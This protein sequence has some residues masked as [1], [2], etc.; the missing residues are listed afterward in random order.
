MEKIVINPSPEISISIVSHGQANLVKDLLQ[1]IERYCQN[2]FIEVL[3]TLN[4]EESLPFTPDSFSFP[5]KF[6]NNNYPLGFGANHNQAFSHASG[7][8]FCVLNPD[9]R[10]DINPFTI[11]IN[12]LKNDA[13]GIVAPI[14][15]S[16]NNTIEDSARQFP[17][18]F[19][20]ICKA[21]GRRKGSDYIIQELPI[22]PDWVGGMFMLFPRK[23][24]EQLNG[25]DEGYFLYYEDVDLCARLRL[26]NYQI[27]LCPEV[28]VYHCAQRTSHS[29]IKYLRWHLS[30][31]M[32]FF[33]SRVFWKVVFRK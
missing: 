20:I 17:T 7:Q 11:L 32:R 15:L 26:S 24:Y 4:I 10:L 25:F 2:M 29:N 33:F 18:P 28:K 6:I 22:Y 31:M 19:K 3:F 21:L 23:I 13:I 12:Q 5:I 1:D 14:V 16:R 30:S 8:F 27:M 9:I